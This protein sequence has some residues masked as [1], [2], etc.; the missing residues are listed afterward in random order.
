M[1]IPVYTYEKC[2]QQQILY[3]SEI[4]INFNNKHNQPTATNHNVKPRK[5]NEQ[6]EQKIVVYFYRNTLMMFRVLNFF[7]FET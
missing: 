3:C 1:C 6:N 7:F 2:N 5:Y 4:Y